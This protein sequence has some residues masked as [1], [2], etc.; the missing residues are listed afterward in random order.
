M[1]TYDPR[2]I[3]RSI[4]T[5][6]SEIQWFTDIRTET[7]QQAGYLQLNYRELADR[8]LRWSAIVLDRAKPQKISISLIERG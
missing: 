2:V 7:S 6:E 3:F 1:P 4:D 5:L 8:V